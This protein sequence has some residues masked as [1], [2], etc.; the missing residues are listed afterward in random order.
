MVPSSLQ[1]ITCTKF[2]LIKKA[3][4]VRIYDEMESNKAMTAPIKRIQS[5]IRI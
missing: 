1:T 4:L 3:Y 5:E 2:L